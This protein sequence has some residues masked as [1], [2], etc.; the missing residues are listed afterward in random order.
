M[1]TS[2]RPFVGTFF[3]LPR[4]LS[5][6]PKPQPSGTLCVGA[7][8]RR[9]TFCTFSS[10]FLL[11]VALWARCCGL[12]A[13][14]DPGGEAPQDDPGGHLGGNCWD[15]LKLPCPTYTL[16]T[17]SG[18]QHASSQGRR[19]KREPRLL[20]PLLPWGQGPQDPHLVAIEEEKL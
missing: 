1:V 2:T 7:S 8:Q 18:L 9:G 5:R 16:P 3:P 10:R 15:P 4:E 11:L 6:H 17:P 12:E 14:Q 13:R 20:E 19:H